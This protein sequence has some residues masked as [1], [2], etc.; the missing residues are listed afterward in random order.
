MSL[1]GC[2][3]DAIE[4]FDVCLS[5][6]ITLGTVI[7]VFPNPNGSLIVQRDEKQNTAT[8]S[9]LTNFFKDSTT[10]FNEF[11][12]LIIFLFKEK[13]VISP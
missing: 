6:A 12:W 2:T 10:F 8:N 7:L 5:S 11:R 1:T 4:L 13:S 3:G 9:K